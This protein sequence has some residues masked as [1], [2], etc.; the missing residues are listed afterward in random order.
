MVVYK[1]NAPSNSVASSHIYLIFSIYF[2]DRV[3][4]TAVSASCFL[5]KHKNTILL[6]NYL[7][8]F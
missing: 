2:L 8:F 4:S 5:Y 3:L 6:L 1:S 7:I